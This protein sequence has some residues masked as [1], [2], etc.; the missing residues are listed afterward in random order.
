MQEAQICKDFIAE[1]QDQEAYIPLYLSCPN[2]HS[3]CEEIPQKGLN[4]FYSVYI[5]NLPT[6]NPKFRKLQLISQDPFQK[7]IVV[8]FDHQAA[9]NK[10]LPIFTAIAAIDLPDNTTIL[11]QIGEAIH[12]SRA[13]HSL[14][15]EFQMHEFG[16]TVNSVAHH[17][18]GTQ[19]IVIPLHQEY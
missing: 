3:T 17:H 2:G 11:V 16:I 13:Q 15:F 7:A 5:W 6:R 1:L 4:L 9:Q 10:G 8:G 14:L 18:G 12:N 19:N